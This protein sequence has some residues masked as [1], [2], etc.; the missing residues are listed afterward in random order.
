[1][2][3]LT[4]SL[5]LQPLTG[6][7]DAYRL[8]PGVSLSTTVSSQKIQSCETCLI[9]QVSRSCIRWICRSIRFA[10]RV[11]CWHRFTSCLPRQDPGLIQSVQ[12]LCE[13][14]NWCKSSIAETDKLSDTWCCSLERFSTDWPLRPS[15]YWKCGASHT[16]ATKYGKSKVELLVCTM[17]ISKISKTSTLEFISKLRKN[18]EA[19]MKISSPSGPK[20]SVQTIFWFRP[21]GLSVTSV[22]KTTADHLSETFAVATVSLCFH[23][24]LVVFWQILRRFTSWAFQGFHS[25]QIRMIA[26]WL[27]ILGRVSSTHP[28][29]NQWA[30][31]EYLPRGNG[32]YL[33]A[34]WYLPLS[35]IIKVC[36]CCFFWRSC[37][38][39]GKLTMWVIE[40][41]RVTHSYFAVIRNLPN[42]SLI[43]SRCR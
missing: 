2:E 34:K 43:H 18:T 28:K 39:T 30:T 3:S 9:L 35:W 33:M 36:K 41:R 4:A 1:M 13:R 14:Q 21:I 7:G 10:H 16:S 5:I 15:A 12:L 32:N 29:A 6:A 23:S 24:C 19:K 42:S 37:R 25:N 22:S 11:W 20:T 40:I 17:V 8:L 26:V 38:L 31:C 27:P